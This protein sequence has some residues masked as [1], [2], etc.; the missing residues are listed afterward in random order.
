MP[1]PTQPEERPIAIGEWQRAFA[2]EWFRLSEGKADMR[3]AAEFAA[4]LYRAH[5]DQDPVQVARE[6][7][8]APT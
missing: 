6:Q 4:E 1:L 5:R 8:D 7:W 3:Q 2:D